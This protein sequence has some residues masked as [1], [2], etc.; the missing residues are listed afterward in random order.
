MQ[1]IFFLGLFGVFYFLVASATV[2]VTQNAMQIKQARVQQ[3][4][5]MF[6]D[7][8]VAI[9]KGVLQEQIDLVGYTSGNS[10]NLN[11]LAE[12][13]SWTQGQMTTDIWQNPVQTVVGIEPTT[14]YAIGPG[15]GAVAD[16]AHIA[17][18]SPGPDRIMQ[19]SMPSPT[20][21]SIRAL[22]VPDESD[23]IVVKF[24]TYDSMIDIW[25]RAQ[26]IDNTIVSAARQSYA[27]QVRSFTDF[28]NPDNELSK[29]YRCVAR[30]DSN[31]N[32]GG[33]NC[34]LYSASLINTCNAL[35]GEDQD[36]LAACWKSEPRLRTQPNFP[37]M[38]NDSGLS[39]SNVIVPP[40]NLGVQ[41]EV[42]RDPFGRV[43]NLIYDSS[44][45]DQI[46]LV[47]RLQSGA[48]DINVEQV[49]RGD[50]ISVAP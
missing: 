19:T 42:D 49:V 11:N 18:M 13:T 23:D 26:K 3:V 20:A 28:S 24:S 7:I 15:M 21:S 10:L 8:R 37:N 36:A 47:R 5:E 32:S 1:A 14:L 34:N 45:P 33:L 46:R 25:N 27:A 9:D 43:L 50:S 6:E 17:I 31:Y 40:A 30:G 35:V 41:A 12:F 39:G 38:A 44:N 4:E 22:Q 16:I 29:F 2:G 48:W